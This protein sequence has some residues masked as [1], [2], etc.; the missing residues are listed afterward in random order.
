MRKT[1]LLLD[2]NFLCWR[3]FHTTG[4]LSHGV[5]FG[6]LKTVQHLSE[7]MATPH[8][9]FCFDHGES[10]R[11]KLL[12]G[13]KAKRHSKQLSEEELEQIK[14]MR[15]QIDRLKTTLLGEC[16]F[17]NV[18]YRT[19]YE[20][21]DMIARAVEN[22]PPGDEGIIVSGDHDM[23]QLIS[24]SVCVWNPTK[25]H[26]T[27]LESFDAEYGINPKKWIDVKAIAGC[28]SDEIPG[29]KGV[30]EET[31]A[32]YLAGKLKPES[33]A[34]KKIDSG[35][36]IWTANLKL[37]TLP[38]HDTPVLPPLSVKTVDQRTWNQ[39]TD[40]FGMKTLKDKA[41]GHKG[42]G[43]GIRVRGKK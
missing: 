11:K 6:F 9:V 41:P 12:P 7:T 31:A 35:S 10:K 15:G 21:D 16:G 32:K 18:F 20:A 22:I 38:F 39:A 23:F 1:W 40:K 33:A 14:E 2:A 27:T 3:A 36:A 42:T 37:V 5:T 13:Y 29:I 43:F 34:Y 26:M 17:D 30:G 25:K 28:S 24:P 4:R 8:L 19:G